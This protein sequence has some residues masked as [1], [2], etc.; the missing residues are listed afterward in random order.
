MK[1]FYFRYFERIL[2]DFICSWKAQVWCSVWGKSSGGLT[3]KPCFLNLYFIVKVNQWGVLWIVHLE[4]KPWVNSFKFEWIHWSVV[5][6]S[7]SNLRGDWS[8]LILPFTP[9]L[10]GAVSGRQWPQGWRSE[11][12]RLTEIEQL[13][14]CCLKESQIKHCPQS[15]SILLLSVRIF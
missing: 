12:R 10:G 2:L 13:V 9:Q 8:S 14:R 7:C 1:L 6:P 4:W 5:P 3:A 11:S 15:L